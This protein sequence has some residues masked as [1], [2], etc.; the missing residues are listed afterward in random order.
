MTTAIVAVSFDEM[1]RLAE[2]VAKSGLFGMKT[3]DQALALMA[4]A[5]AEGQHPALAARDYHIVQGRPVMKSDAMLARFQAAG[6][7]MEMLCYTD[8]KVEAKFSHPQGGSV[9]LDWTTERAKR[10]GLTNK[11]VWKS[12][13]RNMLR[14]RVISEGIRTVFP[15]AT[16]TLLT[17][18]EAMDLPTAGPELDVTPQKPATGLTAL[19]A[20][21]AEVKAHAAPPL[22]LTPADP[23]SR[24]TLADVLDAIHKAQDDDELNGAGALANALSDGDKVIA[25]KAWRERAKEL[26]APPAEEATA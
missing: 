20:R 9:T 22:E 5:Q 23:P 17:P 14:A 4:I 21:V 10:A 15:G 6:G 13:P 25:R 16:Q 18:E 1:S 19:Q 2:A 11:D 24:V 26:T 3:A 8:E 12:Y 7:R